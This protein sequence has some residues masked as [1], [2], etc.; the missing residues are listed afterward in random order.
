[1]RRPS[2]CKQFG[3]LEIRLCPHHL[4]PKDGFHETF[5]LFGTSAEARE[6]LVEFCILQVL[7]DFA[8]D[9]VG[10][11]ETTCL[12]LIIG[13]RGVSMQSAS[14]RHQPRRAHL[15]FCMDCHGERTGDE[16]RL[17]VLTGDVRS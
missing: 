16:M 9:L 5:Q 14:E 12:C 7:G 4:L 3:R 17:E 8:N 11:S 15:F 6:S 13:K 10:N 1:M 2:L